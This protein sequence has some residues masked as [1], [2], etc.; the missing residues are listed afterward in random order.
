MKFAT[1]L[2]VLAAMISILG[3]CSHEVSHTESDKADWFGGG[4][5]RTESTV[6]RNPDGSLSTE[7]SRQTTH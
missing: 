1:T 6:T 7:T 2:F 5:T 4:R 3:A